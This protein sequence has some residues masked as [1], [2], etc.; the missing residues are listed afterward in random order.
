MAH[1]LLC[2]L[3]NANQEKVDIGKVITPLYRAF[4]SEEVKE[5]VERFI[6]AIAIIS[7]LVHL[8]L[9]FLNVQGV[10]GLNEKILPDQIAAIYTPFSFILIYEVYLL[11][12][13]LPKSITIY[14]GKQY[15]IIT[16]IVIRRI[17]KDI[18]YVDLTSDWF[19]NKYD[20]QFTYDIFTS[21]ILFFLIF[22]F[23][24]GVEKRD[25]TTI[26]KPD[27]AGLSVQKFVRLK[28]SLA[29]LLVPVLFVLALYDFT[30]WGV[31]T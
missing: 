13:F 25:Y 23:Y 3:H 9:I 11:V 22:L 2:V 20:L 17:F 27:R 16:L 28:K 29:V 1:K 8:L 19:Q 18:A 15:E 21:L 5:K 24:R 6:L 30:K 7:Y 10:V 26:S 31:T 4:L 12:Y 14:I